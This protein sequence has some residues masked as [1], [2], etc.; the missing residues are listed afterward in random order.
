[1]SWRVVAR[2]RRAGQP[3][4][5]RLQSIK[6]RGRFFSGRDFHSHA[7]RERCISLRSR[8]E[9]RTRNV[10]TLR[11]Q[12]RRSLRSQMGSTRTTRPGIATSFT[13]KNRRAGLMPMKTWPRRASSSFQFSQTG[14][15]HARG[16]RTRD[17]QHRIDRSALCPG[18]NDRAR[19]PAAFLESARTRCRCLPREARR[20][21]NHYRG[22]S[23]VRRL[24]TRHVHRDAR[25]LHRDRPSGRRARYSGRTGPA[26]SR[27]E[28]C[29]IAF[30]IRRAPEFNSVDASLWY[31]IAVNDYLRAAKKQPTLTDDCHTKKLRAAVEA[32]LAGSLTALDSAFAPTPT[33][34]SR[35]ANPA[36]SS[37]GWTRASMVARS[38][39]ASASRWKSRRSG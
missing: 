16:R 34:C 31:V 4:S 13:P 28:C 9:W 35:P 18:Q 23:V 27:K 25:P 19:P 15:A 3:G 30:P 8:A 33:D 1:M 11:R 39:R 14:G 6:V 29:R 24:G 7:S 38:L 5:H 21:Q 12:S 26:S 32:I 36:S 22:L 2:H 17:H 37:P 10:S 20:R